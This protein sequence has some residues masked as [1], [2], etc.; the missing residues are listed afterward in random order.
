MS[1]KL[2]K[3]ADR[4]SLPEDVLPGV[5]RVTLTGAQQVL[6]ENPGELL[7]YSDHT[8]ELG[9]GRYRL[10]I[11]GDHLLLRAMSRESLMVAGSVWGV[12]VDGG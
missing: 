2:G 7:N 6:V 8:V 11:S 3:L 5:P 4:L 1:G 10:R 9:C 12:E